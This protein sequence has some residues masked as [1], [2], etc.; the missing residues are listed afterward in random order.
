MEGSSSTPFFRELCFIITYF[1]VVNMKLLYLFVIA[2]VVQFAPA[3]EVG[4]DP[5]SASLSFVTPEILR[6][7]NIG[8][9]VSDVDGTLIDDSHKMSQHTIDSV[10]ALKDSGLPFFIAT[11]RPRR[12]MASVTGPDFIDALGGDIEAFSGVFS[13]GNEVYGENGVKIHSRYLSPEVVVKTVEFGKEH[14]IGVMAAVGDRLFCDERTDIIMSVTDHAI[15]LPEVFEAGIANLQDADMTVNA[16]LLL[17]EEE[18]LHSLRFKLEELVSDK[19]TVTTSVVGMMEIIPHGASKGEGVR[20]LLDH[21]NMSMDSAVAFGDGENDVEMLRMVRL[22]IAMG[23]AAPV[24]KSVADAVTATNNDNGVAA[25][26][27]MILLNRSLSDA[28]TDA[29]NH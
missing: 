10:R 15:A 7:F 24:L 13:Q 14:N 21:Y 22:G 3:L 12:S 8:V 16:L 27:D 11:G 6:S 23:N 25:V 19:A 9:V 5:L 18:L 26:L 29:G 1:K 4:I 28:T 17:Q 20:I 2:V